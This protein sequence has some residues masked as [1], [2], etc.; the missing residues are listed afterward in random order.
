MS[1]K[2]KNNIVLVTYAHPD[3]YPPTL[4]AI[5][6]LSGLYD[7]VYLV[8]RNLK[9]LGWEYPA[10]V[11][12]IASKKEISEQEAKTAGLPLKILWFLKY[13]FLLLKTIK[14]SKACNKRM[15]KK[16]KFHDDKMQYFVA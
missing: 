11:E 4:N 12:L 6:T 14:Q 7:K 16:L 3:Y 10:N 8:H 13:T 9:G 2:Y 1:D 15:H 5:E